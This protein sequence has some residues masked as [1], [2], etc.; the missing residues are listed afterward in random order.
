MNIISPEINRKLKE[1]RLLAKEKHFTSE[2]IR[3]KELFV[4]GCF[5]TIYYYVK[6]IL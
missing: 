6:L 4:Y 2:A 3:Q 5:F 1:W